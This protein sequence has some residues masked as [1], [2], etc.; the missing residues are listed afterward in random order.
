M[1]IGKPAGTEM[2]K[3]ETMLVVAFIALVVGFLGGIIFSAFKGGSGAPSTA[4]RPAGPAPADAPGQLTQ[5][6]AGRI[7]ALEREVAANPGNREAWVALGNLYYDTN[8]PDKS[9]RAY[10]KAL[11][12][13]PNDPN[14][15]TDMGV[16]HRSLGNSA[17]AL[18]AFQRAIAVDPRHEI[19]R[20]NTGIVLYYDLKDTEG[21]IQAWEELLK[22]KPNATAP[23]GH[24]LREL[25]EELRSGTTHQ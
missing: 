22:I 16:M 14:V 20:L 24:S 7:L 13:N 25:V 15:L 11:E 4:S 18:D 8:K 10:Q 19:S 23:D 6:D 9:V 17:A 1:A 2:V 21:A 12:L 3:K 5:A